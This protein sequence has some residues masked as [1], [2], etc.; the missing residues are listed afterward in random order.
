MRV[1]FLNCYV[2]DVGLMDSIMKIE[3][4]IKRKKPSQHIVIYPS[5]INSMQK[6]LSLRL[7]VNKS[8]LITTD[9]STILHASKLLK[10]QK[11]KNKSL[12]LLQRKM[13]QRK[14]FN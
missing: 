10:R 6:D 11:L 5:K 7:I 2:D 1:K 12:P 4:I 9:S 3:G 8:P 14:L 13:N